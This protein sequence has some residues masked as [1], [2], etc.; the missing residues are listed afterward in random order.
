MATG[1]EKSGGTAARLAEAS[2]ASSARGCDTA[3]ALEAAACLGGAAGFL[4]LLGT[5]VT[6]FLEAARAWLAFA[7]VVLGPD[8]QSTMCCG[9]VC[10]DMDMTAL[11]I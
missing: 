8:F 6:G 4:E 7:G 11:Q 3:A 10:G 5:D 9:V 1:E 2:E